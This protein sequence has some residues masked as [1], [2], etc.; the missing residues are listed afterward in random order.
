MYASVQNYTA[1]SAQIDR[2]LKSRKEIEDVITQLS[3]FLSIYLIRT[4]DGMTI[5]TLCKSKDS[6]EESARSIL[7]LIKE[8]V[9]ELGKAVPKIT[10]GE[11][12]FQI[13]A[14]EAHI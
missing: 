14:L 7:S 1:A 12:A 8:R 9:P 11:V 10:T 3:G 6:A 13:S 4:L 5:L 2:V